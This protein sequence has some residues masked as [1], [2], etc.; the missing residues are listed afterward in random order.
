MKFIY[1]DFEVFKK[2]W[3]VHFLIENE[4]GTFENKQI[5]D[6]REALSKFYEEHR[7]NSVFVG[8]NNK[9]YDQWIFKGIIMQYDPWTITKAI[10]DRGEPGWRIVASKPKPSIN[11]DLK[12]Q[13]APALSLKEIEAN[14]GMN[15]VETPVDF[16]IERDLTQEEK[17]EVMKY[18]VHDVEATYK[19]IQERKEWVQVKIDLIRLY[20]LELSNMQYTTGTITAK[21]LDAK[22]VSRIKTFNYSD[23]LPKELLITKY[24]EAVNFYCK[25]QLDSLK[26]QKMSMDIADV[27]HVVSTGGIHGAENKVFYKTDSKG[28]LYHCDVESYYPAIMIEYNMLSRSMQWQEGFIKMRD[29]RVQHKLRNEVGPAFAKKIS[30]NTVYGLGS[31]EGSNL[32][33]PVM[34]MNVCITG[35]LF[36]IDLIEKVEEQG[37]KLIQSNTDGIIIKAPKDKVD[38]IIKATEVWQD[39]TRFKL[40]NVEIDYIWQKDVNNYILKLKNG[41]IKV[42]GAFVKYWKGGNFVKNHASIIDEAVVKFFTE[43]IKPEVT[44]QQATNP[45]I[46]YQMVAKSGGMY[47]KN[48]MEYP[49]GREIEIQNVNRVFPVTT[50][51]GQI[52]KYKYMKD[53]SESKQKIANLPE[54]AFIINE[55]IMNLTIG[56][57]KNIDYK[58]YISEA[59]SRIKQFVNSEMFKILIQNVK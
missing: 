16:K 51:G 43:F 38:D 50:N 18:C 17:D 25:E 13:L 15:I 34:R 41:K 40:E 27:E 19:L 36:L 49:N 20:D 45:A 53:G 55:D 31:Q 4:D 1:Y 6:D 57:V 48:T 3:G 21:I 12:E 14:L 52:F 22:R 54:K 44:I 37:A 26:S 29:E 11:L 59:W 9:H 33:D 46:K 10:I 2:F 30:I 39:R 5:R 47:H 8:F 42:K 56:D 23:Y 24:Q 28:T 32:Y 7:L 35:Q 58:F